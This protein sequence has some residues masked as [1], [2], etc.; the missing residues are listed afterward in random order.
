MSWLAFVLIALKSLGDPDPFTR[1]LFV[2]GEGCKDVLAK[3]YPI[4]QD[5]IFS[6]TALPLERTRFLGE[7]DMNTSIGPF[8]KAYDYFGDGSMYIVDAPGSFRVVRSSM[9]RD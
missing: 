1:A 8:P 2:V 4:V 5:A 9:A 7:S 3:G 6:S